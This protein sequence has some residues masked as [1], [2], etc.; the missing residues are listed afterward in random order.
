MDKWSIMP[1]RY[2]LEIKQLSG[3]DFRWGNLEMKDHWLVSAR[4][5]SSPIAEGLT[6]TW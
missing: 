5:I 6:Y 1:G 3:S 2:F 4:C